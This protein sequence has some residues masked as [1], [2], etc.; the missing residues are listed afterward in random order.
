ALLAAGGALLAGVT[1]K[2]L[3]RV[4]ARRL[5]ALEARTPRDGNDR[6][7]RAGFLVGVGDVISVGANEAWLEHA[8]LLS[9]AG[10]PVAALLFA[11]DAT[12]VA[13]PAQRKSVFWSAERTLEF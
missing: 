9:E 13:L 1:A 2:A 6:L 5:A 7:A 3:S 11:R 12:L 10:A 8:W 4:R